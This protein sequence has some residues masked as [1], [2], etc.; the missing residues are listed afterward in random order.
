ME[1]EDT[2]MRLVTFQSLAA[3]KDLV[4][5]GYLEC[6]EEYV[7]LEKAGVVYSWVQEKMNGR[8]KNHAGTK[9]PIWCW[10]RCYNNICPPK[11]KG[12]P[13]EGFDVKITFSKSAHEVFITDFRRYSFLLHNTYI[14]VSSDDRERFDK[15]LRQ[16]AITEEDLA[17]YVRRDRY[18]KHRTDPEYLAACREIRKSF[19][20]CITADSDILQ[21]CVWRVYLGEIEDI[22][23]LHDKSYRYGSLNYRRKDGKRPNWREEF[24]KALK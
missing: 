13:V 20:R 2:A 18:E 7:D 9:F 4:S 8:I 14:P 6:R 22:E 3:L 21:G 10:V 16:A 19:D 5:R 12:E 15:R 23:L 11:R 1:A 24:Y 17:A